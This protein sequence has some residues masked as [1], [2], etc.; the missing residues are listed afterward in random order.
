MIFAKLDLLDVYIYS[1][2]GS[3]HYTLTTIHFHSSYY[4]KSVTL[5]RIHLILLQKLFSSF[6]GAIVCRS[7]QTRHAD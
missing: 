2:E 3:L 7:I 4:E 1:K 5:S 6:V